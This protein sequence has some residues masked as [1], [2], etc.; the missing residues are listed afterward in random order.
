M[1]AMT[2]LQHR[3]EGWEN[4]VR[5]VAVT[6]RL[7]REGLRERLAAYDFSAP[8]DLADLVE[9]VSDLLERGAVH[10]NHP[11]YFGLFNT[12]VRRAG[13]VADALVALYNPQVGGWWHSP[14]ACEIEQH[15]LDH[16]TKKIGFDAASFATFTTG[17]S[18][19]NLTGVLSALAHAFPRYAKE[20]LVAAAKEPVFYGSDQAHD[21]FVKTARITGL[22]EGAFRRV[23]SDARQRLDVNDLR[24][25]IRRDKAAGKSPF[26]AVAT[27]GTTSTGAIDPMGEMAAL[28][29]EEGLWL[30]ADAAW[31]GIA[32]LSDALKKHVAGL[33]LA[34]SVTWD[35]HKTFP[36]PMGA[37][38]FF[39]R[40][41]APSEA[42]F[43]VH[44]AYVQDADPGTYDLYQRSV[45]WSR[46]LIGLKVFVTLAE[47]GDRGMADLVDHQSRMAD[48][49]RQRL[50]AREFH[51]E[52]DSPL[53]IVCFSREGALA[54][55]IARKVA[56]EGDAWL[57]E[58]RVDPKRP[59]LRA[60]I[61]HYD[62]QLEDVER[63][64]KAVERA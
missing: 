41:H 17:G 38:M 24:A 26:L 60:C 50:R 47:L 9:G 34:D 2:K 22:G 13:I 43:S 54:A 40:T 18:E 32:L 64:I 1:D 61:T 5:D 4:R 33:S 31:G 39:C 37:G 56:A 63:L 11:R 6:P 44:T 46:R 14:A 57:S 52:N 20:G 30:H 55:D 27:V 21:S 42:L 51:I 45:Q 36:V 29:R 62:T 49:L 53:P 8:R 10:T 25:A 12:G 48:A 16:L 59:W 15:T 3:I 7:P 23:R 28:C 19:A 35:A 58:V